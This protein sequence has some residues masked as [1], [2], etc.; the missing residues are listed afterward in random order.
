MAFTIDSATAR[1]TRIT[2]QYEADGSVIVAEVHA[3]VLRSDGTDGASAT[4]LAGT[5]LPAGGM[6]TALLNLADQAL[7]RLKTLKRWT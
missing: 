7:T 2:I 5:V 1:V 6:K 4:V 3:E